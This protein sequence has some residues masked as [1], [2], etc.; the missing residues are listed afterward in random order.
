MM[1]IFTN[2]QF[3]YTMANVSIMAYS[4]YYIK[5]RKMGTNKIKS[6]YQCVTDF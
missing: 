3:K 2:A 1:H 4:K 5:F 6:I